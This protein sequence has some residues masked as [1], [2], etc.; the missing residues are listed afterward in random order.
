MTKPKTNPAI[1]AV[2]APGECSLPPHSLHHYIDDENDVT[3]F[4]TLP[5]ETALAIT[6][7]GVS[8]AVMMVT[9][10]DIEDFVYGFSY[11]ERVIRDGS[12]IHDIVV[13][14]ENDALLAHVTLAN[15]AHARMSLT[16]RHLAGRTGCGICGAESLEHAIPNLE[17][18]NHVDPLQNDKI[19]KLRDTLRQWQSLGHISGAIHAALLVNSDGDILL[20][21]EDIG[22][23]NALDKV[24][25]A[26]LRG[27]I[28]KDSHAL[29]V[30]SRCSIELV[31]KAV[32]AGV[33]TLITLGTPT[34]LAVNTAIQA[35]L[36]LIHLP[37]KDAPRFYNRA[38]TG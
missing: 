32:M 38:A 22:R 27:R 11:S 33:G 9:P 28:L 7:N 19:L 31:Q 14:T 30:T 25:G 12:E 21:R 36:N 18:L 37:R 13:D 24:L 16:K 1:A 8:H 29:L 3:C 35:N 23:H 15:R 17:P 20:C 5:T 34:S 10:Q 6:F 26:A 4:S 2:I